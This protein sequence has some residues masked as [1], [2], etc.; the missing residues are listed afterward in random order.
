MP[1]ACRVGGLKGSSVWLLAQLWLCQVRVWG[2][3]LGHSMACSVPG[4]WEHIPGQLLTAAQHW[5]HWCLLGAELGS[6]SW[7]WGAPAP[8]GSPSPSLSSI[9]VL[10]AP[11]RAPSRALGTPQSPPVS[12]SPSSE[13]SP[14]ESGQ[15]D[16]PWDRSHNHTS[17]P[18]K[19][20][21]AHPCSLGLHS[22]QAQLVHP[23]DHFS[24]LLFCA[25]TVSHLPSLD[26]EPFLQHE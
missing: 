4:S 20:H 2:F 15:S 18:G 13:L 8:L 5:S 25:V 26:A 12:G 23:L 24:L 3:S 17:T 7:I 6:P 9:S 21:P 22:L 19:L 14:A 11:T 10:A 1:C 16:Q